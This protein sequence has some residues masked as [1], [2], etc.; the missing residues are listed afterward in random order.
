VKIGDIIFRVHALQRMFERE[1]SVENVRQALDTGEVI[2]DYSGEMPEPA[3]LILGHRRKQ[4]FHVVISENAK[5]NDV[6]IITVYL[7]DP[8]KW[9]KGNRTRRS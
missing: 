3:M 4:S 7:P 6:T 2:E 1:I 5:T 8:H 9:K